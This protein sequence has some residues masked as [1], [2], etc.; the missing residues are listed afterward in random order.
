MLKTIWDFLFYSCR[1]RWKTMG[2][3]PVVNTSGVKTGTKY[4]LQC[5]KCGNVKRKII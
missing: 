5:V 1:H 3:N 4:H 2:Y